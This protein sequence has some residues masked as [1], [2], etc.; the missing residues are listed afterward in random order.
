MRLTTRYRAWTRATGR[1]VYGGSLVGSH[2]VL[3]LPEVCSRHGRSGYARRM[4]DLPR[5]TAQPLL[6]SH[7]APMRTIARPLINDLCI[8]ARGH[9]RSG[10]PDALAPSGAGWRGRASEA[11]AGHNLVCSSHLVPHDGGSAFLWG[12]PRCITDTRGCTCVHSTASLTAHG[13]AWIRPYIGAGCSDR[14]SDP[15]QRVL[16]TAGVAG[17]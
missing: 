1:S 10:S 3:M 9:L 6:P 17:L 7:H 13:A 15:M 11:P 8:A 14:R 2:P 4:G 16:K 5:A 12:S